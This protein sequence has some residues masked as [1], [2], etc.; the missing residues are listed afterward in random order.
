VFTAILMLLLL[1][2]ALLLGVCGHPWPGITALALFVLLI[3]IGGN[4]MLANLVLDSLETPYAHLR[5]PPWGERNAVI[6]LGHGL[7]RPPGTDTLQPT[8]FS[9][10]R[11]MESLRLYRHCVAG[12][13]ACKMVITGGSKIGPGD[14]EA[15]ICGRMARELGL[16]E[17]DLI[18]EPASLNTFRN[19]ELT[20][21]IIR[22]NGFD[23]II[24][25]T[26]AFHMRRSLLYFAN[27]DVVCEGSMADYL[28]AVRTLVPTGVNLA[29]TD[30]ALNE[31]LGIL[32]YRIYTG[33]GWNPRPPRLFHAF[34]P[35]GQP[36][37]MEANIHQTIIQA[38]QRMEQLIEAKDA[39]GVAANYTLT[40]RLM[41]P[42]R[43]ILQGTAAIRGFWQTSLEPEIQRVGL[44]TLEVESHGEAVLEI[45]TYTA[46]FQ[47][48]RIADRGT[49]LV[50]WQQEDGIWKR[51][52][53]MWN[54]NRPIQA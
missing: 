6:L 9:Y 3:W 18:L 19:A 13:K 28:Q 29:L 42:H 31:Y 14:S 27:F 15:V 11:I 22:A 23:R 20:S 45:G 5:A 2:I 17:R 7:V 10:S 49:Y 33:L 25:V 48:G 54:T 16:P 39:A 38:E 1:P 51:H 32:R 44:E 34:N 26:S 37:P 41:S 43:E 4:G 12:G 53:D 24:L 40:A 8:V 50:L 35:G 52:R 47:D 21:R 36:M 46:V 30:L